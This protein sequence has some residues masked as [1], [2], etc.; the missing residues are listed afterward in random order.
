MKKTFQVIH[1]FHPHYGKKF[2]LVNYRN[3][4]KNKYLEYIDKDGISCCIPLY[5]TDAADIDPFVEI[6]NGRSFF[7]V[8]DLLRLCD[9]VQDLLQKKIKSNSKC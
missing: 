4:W 7:H 8:R 1:P 5:C 2:E 9:L 6:S 3:S